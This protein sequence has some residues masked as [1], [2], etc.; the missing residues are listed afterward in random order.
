MSRVPRT[1]VKG[2]TLTFPD[3]RSCSAYMAQ[4]AE[5]GRRYLVFLFSLFL[6]FLFSCFT[7]SRLGKRCVER[8]EKLIRG[9]PQGFGLSP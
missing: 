4:L 8:Q 2:N 6:Y 3:D 7:E 9:R 5:I 1:A